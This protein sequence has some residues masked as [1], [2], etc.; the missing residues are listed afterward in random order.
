MPSSASKK[1]RAAD[2]HGAVQIC[3]VWTKIEAHVSCLHL[4]VAISDEIADVRCRRVGR[5]RRWD[6]TALWP[7]ERARAMHALVLA[8][9]APAPSL[10]E[11]SSIVRAA[12]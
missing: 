6:S 1:R 11:V 7:P 3:A 10:H 4:E 2:R 8:R 12:D 9:D 5:E